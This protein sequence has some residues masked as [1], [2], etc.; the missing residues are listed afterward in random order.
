MTDGNVVGKK[1]FLKEKFHLKNCFPF[2]VTEK[3]SA[4]LYP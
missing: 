3:K 1:V 2:I 4:I